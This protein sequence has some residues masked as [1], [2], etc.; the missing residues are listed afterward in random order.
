V[1]SVVNWPKFTASVGFTPAATFVSVTGVPE[2]APPSV[3]FVCAVSSYW[4][5]AATPV[6]SEPSAVDVEVDSVATLLFIV[7][8]PVLSTPTLLLVVDNPVFSA[9]TLLCVVLMPDEAEVDSTAILLFVVDRPVDNE[10]TPLCTV[11]MP[12]DVDVDSAATLLFVLDTAVDNE[13]MPVDV[14]VD[15]VKSCAPFIAS[16]LVADTVPAASAV[17]LLEFICTTP[18]MEIP[19]VPISSSKPLSYPVTRAVDVLNP[20]PPVVVPV[21]L[22]EKSLPGLLQPNPL[23][24]AA[25]PEPHD[26]PL[27]GLADETLPPGH[28]CKLPPACA[29]GATPNTPVTTQA[30]ADRQPSALRISRRAPP[31][32]APPPLPCP[33]TSS[34]TATIFPLRR[35]TARR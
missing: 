23:P 5:A 16:V 27:P 9:T 14:A 32:P 7:D 3:T 26:E 22:S 4:T 19:P 2:P 30:I 24:A 12:V 10:P 31:E 20:P 28:N 33:R 13:L 21:L 18:S 29:V 34:A 15:N 25:L 8:S 17:I 6:D 1:E 35:L 11:L